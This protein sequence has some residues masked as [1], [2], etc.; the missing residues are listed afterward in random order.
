MTIS[1]A[2]AELKKMGWVMKTPWDRQSVIIWK[3]P[4]YDGVSVEY[5]IWAW[6]QGL[7]R[8]EG[9]RLVAET[10]VKLAKAL[11]EGNER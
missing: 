5:H 3:K 7:S 11:E 4:W 8:R 6:K 9:R 1:E 2:R 10:A